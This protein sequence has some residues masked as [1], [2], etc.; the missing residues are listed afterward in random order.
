MSRRGLAAGLALV[1]AAL[2]AP[3]LGNASYPSADRKRG[4][5]R[6]LVA[7]TE[8]SYVLSRQKL[9]AG[10]V[11]VQMT[12]GGEDA[13]NLR[14]QRKGAK[15]SRLIPR[16]EPGERA[17]LNRRLKPGRYYL[18]CS[19]TDHEERGMRAWLVVKRR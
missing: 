3:G 8:F 11:I 9:R 14:L 18:W 16:V 10:R 2:V 1:L 19:I 12:N 5:A 13:H 4:P 7:A 17:E 15:R 6:L